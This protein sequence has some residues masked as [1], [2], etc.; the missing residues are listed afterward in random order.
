LLELVVASLLLLRDVLCVV[1]LFVRGVLYVFDDG[2]AVED[3]TFDL[4][5]LLVAFPLT[6]VRVGVELVV[7]VLR[8]LSVVP[9]AA[10]RV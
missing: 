7:A 2:V 4:V 9:V 1:V 8:L 5:L 6:L 10:E 3:D